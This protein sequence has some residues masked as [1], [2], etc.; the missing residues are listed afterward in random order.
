[1]YR[2][3]IALRYLTSRF[4][5]FAALLVVASGVALLIVILSVMEGF[6][7]D[8][9]DRIR[10]TSSDM[11]VESKSLL[12]MKDPETVAA[13]VK[14]A[15]GVR[16]VS[17]FVESFA[18]HRADSES[19][20]YVVEGLDLAD[21]TALPSL[22]GY[23]T[24]ARDRARKSALEERNFRFD[25]ESLGAVA[26]Q[27]VNPQDLLSPAWLER[28][29]WRLCGEPR[30]K[31]KLPPPILVGWEAMRDPFV[32]LPPGRTIRLASYSPVQNRAVSGEFLVAG[33]YLSRDYQ[34]DSVT[35]LIPLKAS[36][37]FLELRDPMTGRERVSGVRVA[38]EGDLDRTKAA[39][40][41]ALG[42]MPGLRVRTWKEEKASLLRAVRIEKLVVGV[43][44]GVLIVFGGL[45]VFIVLT[46]Q[47]VEKTRDIGVLQ[48][49]GSTASGIA[50]IYLIIGAGVCLVGM[51]VGGLLGV[52]FCL[53]L[54]TLQRWIYVLTGFELFPRNVYYIDQIPVRM[55]PVDL[56]FIIVPTMVASLL[57][58]V[59]PA[60]RA[61][62]KDPVAALRYE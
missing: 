11:R 28:D 50:F 23:L 13:R 45:M 54:G 5:T 32:P 40:V 1:M 62:R 27:P 24:A 16:G 31:G 21:E 8:L 43:I 26:G 17:P 15:P 4:I 49:I 35:V 30:P 61:A 10:G 55:A 20:R 44:M 29:L 47:V 38:V 36:V 52:G 6:R 25:I 2:W 9:E 59:V 33:V 41:E 18:I 57:A 53:S 12:G 22:K 34:F 39:V 37:D 19:N 56:I 58:S 42:D 3:F 7:T 48:S 14:S 51:V 46:V 60:V